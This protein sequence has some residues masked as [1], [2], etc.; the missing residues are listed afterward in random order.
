MLRRYVRLTGVVMLAV[1]A[2]MATLMMEST[3]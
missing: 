2:L 1:M 3:L